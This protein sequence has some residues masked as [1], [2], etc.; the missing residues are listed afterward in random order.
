MALDWFNP[1]EP[2]DGLLS[3]KMLWQRSDVNE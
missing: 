1:I 2:L 3:R